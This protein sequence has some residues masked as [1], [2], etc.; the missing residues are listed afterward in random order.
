MQIAPLQQVRINAVSGA[1]RSLVVSA[2]Q[3]PP[4]AVGASQSRQTSGICAFELTHPS[5]SGLRRLREAAIGCGC[6]RRLAS[7]SSKKG[8]RRRA[9]SRLTIYY[10]KCCS[11]LGAL[12][13]LL[14]LRHIQRRVVLLYLFD[15]KCCILVQYYYLTSASTIVSTVR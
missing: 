8:G 11:S 7:S 13:L 14:L 15:G 3:A 4:P 12:L 2:P 1:I 6:C 9:P 5:V 10:C